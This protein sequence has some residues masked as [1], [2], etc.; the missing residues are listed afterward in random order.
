M[1]PKDAAIR[2]LGTV[3]AW[4]ELNGGVFEARRCMYATAPNRN[5]KTPLGLYAWS[6]GTSTRSGRAML[7]HE[8]ANKVKEPFTRKAPIA[9]DQ[10]SIR[11]ERLI[12]PLHNR[13]TTV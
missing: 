11:E 13:T 7:N 3:S 10:R 2:A 12:L 6:G 1:S 4:S 5:K 8:K 9:E